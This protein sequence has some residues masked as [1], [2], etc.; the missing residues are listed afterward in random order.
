MSNRPY[1]CFV[2]FVAL[3]S[4]TPLWQTLLNFS[5]VPV[6]I[7]LGQ[8]LAAFDDFRPTGTWRSDGG[9]CKGFGS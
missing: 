8:G 5:L 6:V 1:C 7:P 2:P 3:S 4:S 9:S